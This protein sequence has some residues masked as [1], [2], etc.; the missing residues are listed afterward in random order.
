M[1]SKYLPK[2][3]KLQNQK[4]LIFN[5]YRSIKSNF[6]SDISVCAIPG[7]IGLEPTILMTKLSRKILIANKSQLF[8]VGI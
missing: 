5:N 4:T 3:K 2:S 8:V 1:I 6:K 7:I